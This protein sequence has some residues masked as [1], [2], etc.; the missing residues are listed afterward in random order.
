ML[1]EDGK[2]TLATLGK[3]PKSFTVANVGSASYCNDGK[4][5]I[6]S[7]KG[8]RRIVLATVG[9]ERLNKLAEKELDFLEP[10]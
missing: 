8:S 10:T 3:K 9:A 6:Y 4:R 7:E 2:L 5:V 1:D